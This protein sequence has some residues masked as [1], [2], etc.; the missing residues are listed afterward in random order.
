MILL[1][2]YDIISIEDLNLLLTIISIM[3]TT[4]NTVVTFGGNIMTTYLTVGMGVTGVTKW[5]VDNYW[6]CGISWKDGIDTQRFESSAPHQRSHIGSFFANGFC[7]NCWRNDMYRCIY[8]NSD[9]LSLSDVIS[10]AL[11]GAKI[12]RKFVCKEHNKFTRACSH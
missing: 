4:I 3:I 12:T 1:A 5:Y 9:D 11:T 7:F 2:I 6:Y 10:C 8:C